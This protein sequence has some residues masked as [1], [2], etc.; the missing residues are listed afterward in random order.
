VIPAIIGGLAA[1][2]VPLTNRAPAATISAVVSPARVPPP[3]RVW[4]DLPATRAGD[5]AAAVE[6]T[7]APLPAPTESLAEAGSGEPGASESSLERN[8]RVMKAFDL[9]ERDATWASRAESKLTSSFSDYK[10]S[11][12]VE[13]LSLRAVE[14]RAS[15]CRIDLSYTSAALALKLQDK[16]SDRSVFSTPCVIHSLGTDAEPGDPSVVQTL[17]VACDEWGGIAHAGM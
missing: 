17:V 16:L 8:A 7:G 6:L 12:D 10:A 3:A 13:G 1:W 14:C 9:E 15:R 4:G 2:I 5:R 11:H